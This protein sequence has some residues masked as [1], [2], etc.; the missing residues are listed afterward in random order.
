MS[1]EEKEIELLKGS[2]EL[3]EIQIQ[4]QQAALKEVIEIAKPHAEWTQAYTK[5]CNVA[6]KGLEGPR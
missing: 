1:E 4:H 3:F 5:I 6:Q 2:I